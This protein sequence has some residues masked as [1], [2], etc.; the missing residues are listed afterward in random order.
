MNKTRYMLAALFA[1]A[2][3]A[4]WPS[5]HAGTVVTHST[6][7]NYAVTTVRTSGT[8][9]G[10]QPAPCCYGRVV[11]TGN[12]SKTVI[13]TAPPPVRVVYTTPPVVVYPTT[14]AV[15][16]PAPYYGTYY[17]SSYYYRP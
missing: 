17:Y 16:V 7:P 13:T 15:Y 1:V 6:T 5:A 8:Y 11:V 4:P 12:T 9:W 2:V 14:R 10:V 3:G